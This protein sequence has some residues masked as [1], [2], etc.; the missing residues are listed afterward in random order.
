[1][2]GRVVFCEENLLQ[3]RHEVACR[4]DG[5]TLPDLKLVVRSRKYPGP[6]VYELPAEFVK[7]LG[8]GEYVDGSRSPAG[9]PGEGL[10]SCGHE[11]GHVFM[12]DVW[13]PAQA[14]IG[15]AL[16]PAFIYPV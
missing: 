4:C 13:Q 11:R 8:G 12:L 5:G 3:E 10:S 16:V 14:E 9:N 6:L 7:Q 2:R 15:E 1:V